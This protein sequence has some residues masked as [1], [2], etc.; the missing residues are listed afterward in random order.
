MRVFRVG[1]QLELDQCTNC[2]L[3]WFDLAEHEKLPNRPPEDLEREANDTPIGFEV[4]DGLR[5]RAGMSPYENI[6]GDSRAFPAVTIGL[7]LAFTLA[8]HLAHSGNG[9]YFIFDGQHP[10][11]G[12]GIPLVL[13][14]FAHADKWHL[15][16]NIFFFFIPATLLEN[17]LGEK[18]LW[19]LFLLAGIGGSLL[20]AVIEPSS[21][22]LGASGGIAG[23]Y[24]ALCLTQPQA[25]YVQ[26]YHEIWPRALPR[27]GLSFF[28]ITARVPLWLF[29]VSWLLQQALGGI[30]QIGGGGGKIGY[31]AHIGGILFGAAY[32]FCSDL[33]PMSPQRRQ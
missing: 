18:V 2:D 6:T 9:G 20:Q 12:F 3:T 13:S 7:I 31:L 29:F 4:E 16:G 10:L 32:V 25:V 11:R 24:T 26:Q 8:T 15:V 22:S 30:V 17:T 14:L 1:A 27:L 28:T 23:I 19:Q 5:F 21:I 33:R